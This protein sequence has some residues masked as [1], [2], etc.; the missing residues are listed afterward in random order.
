MVVCVLALALRGGVACAHVGMHKHTGRVAAGA[1]LSLSLFTTADGSTFKL[2][3]P[4]S[5]DCV[6]VCVCDTE[7]EKGRDGERRTERV[8]C[9]TERGVYT[10]ICTYTYI[11]VCV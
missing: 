3:F 9:V 2:L 4:S 10:Y 5:D 6:C 7:Q 1:A 8:G 11:Y